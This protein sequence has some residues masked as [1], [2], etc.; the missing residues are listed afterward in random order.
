L[1]VANNK[2][3][4]NINVLSSRALV[5]SLETATKRARKVALLE[6]ELGKKPMNKIGSEWPPK[7]SMDELFGDIPLPHDSFA[8]DL[9]VEFFLQSE[10]LEGFDMP[11]LQ[12]YLGEHSASSCLSPS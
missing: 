7:L 2:V 1:C 12:L 10:H 5:T 4:E 8:N 3:N 11:R 6:K 9:L